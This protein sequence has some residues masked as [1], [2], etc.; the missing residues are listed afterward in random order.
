V[1]QYLISGFGLIVPSTVD[2]HAR[3]IESG[4][5][6]TIRLQEYLRKKTDIRVLA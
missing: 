2:F 5:F 6:W 3:E 1:Q 4:R